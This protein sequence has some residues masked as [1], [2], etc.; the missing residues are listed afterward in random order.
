[1][2]RVGHFISICKSV[3]VEAVPA[4]FVRTARLED[5]SDVASM[6]V[7]GGRLHVELDSDR[8]RAA[9][10]EQI[11]E[12]LASQITSGSDLEKG[13][14]LVATY[15]NAVVG[16]ASITLRHAP[17]KVTR[18]REDVLHIAWLWVVPTA[19]RLGIAQ[20]LLD[21]IEARARAAQ[22]PRVECDIVFNNTASRTLFD[23]RGYKKKSV[24][25][26]SNTLEM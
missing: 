13:V 19:R 25:Y 20:A 3:K 24:V 12:L 17:R 22:V 15:G 1:M 21:D 4:V 7:E 14:V 8:Y 10:P 18:K 6:V 26:S 2:E 23:D 5:V 9:N 11:S 16:T